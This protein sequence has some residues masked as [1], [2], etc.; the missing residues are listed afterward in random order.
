VLIVSDVRMLRQFGEVT[1][2]DLT[3]A[4]IGVLVVL[5]AVLVLAERR[6]AGE[7]VVAGRPRLPRL[8][9]LR[10]RRAES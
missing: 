5:P 7:L 1:V 2:V 3:V 6:Q 10:L 8:P 4:L 9:R